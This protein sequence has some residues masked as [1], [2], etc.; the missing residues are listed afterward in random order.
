MKLSQSLEK[1][2]INKSHQKEMTRLQK[3]HS[4]ELEK[5]KLNHEKRKNQ[6]QTAFKLEENSKYHD[7]KIKL[8]NQALRNEKALDKLQQN[9]EAS[10]ELTAKEKQRI[11]DDY[12]DQLDL[13]KQNFEVNA[14]N[15]KEKN[16]YILQDIDQEA[17]YEINRLQSRIDEKRQ[18]IKEIGREKMVRLEADNKRIYQDKKEEYSKNQLNQN[19]KFY[20]ALVKKKAHHQKQIVNEERK[21]QKTIDTRQRV[22]KNQVAMAEKDYKERKQSMVKNHREKYQAQFQK[23][24]KQLQNLLS[25]KEGI[26]QNLRQ[27]LKK[28]AVKELNKNADPFYHGMKLNKN[29][30]YNDSDREYTLEIEIPKHELKNIDVKAYDREIRITMDRNFDFKSKNE[31]GSNQTVKKSETFVSKIPVDHILN[32]KKIT[33]S[34]EDGILSYKIERA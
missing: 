22:Y 17:K 13:I 6:V 5:L 23:Q 10:K 20:S 34:Y 9:L 3:Q 31:D 26:I 12:E 29:L 19:D 4:L 21:F 18:E 32:S 28:E 33:K 8:A 14:K 15:V 30:S 27:M 25:K 2:E 7:N 11:K 1:R 16:E 24:E